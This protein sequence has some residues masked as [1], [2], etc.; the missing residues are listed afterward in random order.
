MQEQLLNNPDLIEKMIPKWQIGCRRLS[1][2][3]GYLRA[4]ME[5]NVT[6]VFKSIKRFTPSGLVDNDDVHH[7]VEA[8][9]CATG[10]SGTHH[11]P[12][13]Q[14]GRA[15]IVLNEKWANDPPCYFGV[16]VDGFPNYFMFGGPYGRKQS[17]LP[18]QNIMLMYYSE[19][20]WPLPQS[21][22]MDCRIYL[23][24]GTENGC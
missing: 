12:W 16:S 3:D 5:E 19:R 18:F 2:G 1:P 10:F 4:I 8:V 22:G 20:P 21:H 14:T 7:E 9:I 13:K 6:N 11:T 15:G 24:M 17:S 23:T